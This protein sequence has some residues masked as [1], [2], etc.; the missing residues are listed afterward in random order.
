WDRITS[1]LA[2]VAT[3]IGE[4]LGPAF[5]FL[6]PVLD[7]IAAGLN[8]IG[9]AGAAIMSKLSGLGDWLGSLFERDVLGYHHQQAI[10][11]NA[12][13]V[14]RRIIDA[15]KTGTAEMFAAGDALI[16]SLWD[17][18]VAK[19]DSLLAWVKTIPSL[20]RN[21]IGR[22]DLSNV[23]RL[24]SFLGGGGDAPAAPPVDGAR[25]SGGPVRGGGTYLV[26]E[27]G[28]ELFSPS[29]SGLIT[30]NSA[31]ASAAGASG[32]SISVV[33]NFTI[34]GAG[35]AEAVAQAVVDRQAEAVKTSVESAYMD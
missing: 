10:E 17:G 25:A 24:P 14:T 2:G 32:A 18:A 4:E 6:R 28:P 23:I 35:N 30:P 29:R 3:A 21:A 27:R 16:Q 31:L 5:E 11:S 9:N 33:N 12:Y 15:F 19:F 13:A 1:T 8:A 20:I 26:G 34:S 22:I 7:P